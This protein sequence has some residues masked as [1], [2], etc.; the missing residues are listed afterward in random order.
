M[1]KQKKLRKKEVQFEGT[2]IVIASLSLSQVEKY[3]NFDPE[4]K[5]REDFWVRQKNLVLMGVNN[6]LEDDEQ[7]TMEDLENQI[8]LEMLDKLG[9]EIIA[10]SK[11]T[12]IKKADATLGEAPAPAQTTSAG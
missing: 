12:V 9:D 7:W 3:I 4:G 1:A 2:S 10:L 6:A 5:V 8:D 11:L